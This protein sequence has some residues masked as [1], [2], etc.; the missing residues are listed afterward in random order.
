MAFI[1]PPNPLL[2]VPTLNMSLN[3]KTN[4]LIFALIYL[5]GACSN[6]Q[7]TCESSYTALH[8]LPSY[9][10][11]VTVV[12]TEADFGIEIPSD[13]P[14]HLSSANQTLSTTEDTSAWVSSE[15]GD[16]IFPRRSS[17][18]ETACKK[19]DSYLLIGKSSFSRRGTLNED[20]LKS[21]AASKGASLVIFEE[22]YQ[23]N[24]YPSAPQDVYVYKVHFYAQSPLA[25]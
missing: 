2:V 21:L 7:V 8:N 24:S 14:S 1:N 5:L 9:N 10:G 13:N 19:Y 11:I 15:S 17:P 3:M 12:K 4:P 18:F 20:Q 22:Y 6:S 23:I 16:L 25:K